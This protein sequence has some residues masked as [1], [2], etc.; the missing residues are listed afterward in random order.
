MLCS[1]MFRSAATSALAALG[2][3]LLVSVLWP[4]VVQFIST[5]VYPPTALQLVFGQPNPDQLGLQ[6]TLSRL[7]PSTLFGE[8]VLGVLHPATRALGLVF[9]SQ[10]QG[11]IMGT[12]LPLGQS[13]LLVWPQVTSLIAGTI[14]LFV[15][16]YVV[17]QREE[18]RA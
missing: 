15:I 2:L 7:S 10:L 18:V 1:V 17:F 5:E 14:I 8:S 12:P 11:A 4:Q 6:Q 3:W 9:A 16:A 13:I